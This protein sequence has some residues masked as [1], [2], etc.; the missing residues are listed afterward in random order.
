MSVQ[1]RK[2]TEEP[3]GGENIAAESTYAA[4][5]SPCAS[6]QR[7]HAREN[8][9]ILA[10][11]LNTQKLFTE[12]LSDAFPKKCDKWNQYEEKKITCNFNIHF[13]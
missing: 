7:D 6:G 13:S 2:P 5:I 3:D 1:V 11:A 4:S 9:E 8:Q 12:P 10:N